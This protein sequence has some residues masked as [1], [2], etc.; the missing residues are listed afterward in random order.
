MTVVLAV[1]G[2]PQDFPGNTYPGAAFALNSGIWRLTVTPTAAS[3]TY[4]GGNFHAILGQAHGGLWFNDSSLELYTTPGDALVFSQLLTW[5]AATPI[6]IT[7]NTRPGAG[8]VTIA[9]ALTGNGTFSFTPQGP[10]V[11]STSTLGIGQFG[12]NFAFVGGVSVIDDTTPDMSWMPWVPPSPTRRAA[13]SAALVAALTFPVLVASAPPAPVMSWSPVIPA[14]QLR[15]AARPLN[16]GGASAPEATLPNASAPPSSWSPVFPDAPRRAR[17][18]VNEGGLVE[19]VATLPNASAPAMSWSPQFPGAPRAAR[20]VVNVGGMTHPE[21]VIPNAAAPGIGWA[22]EFPDLMPRVRYPLASG[23][24]APPFSGGRPLT[25]GAASIRQNILSQLAFS[26]PL[27]TFSTNLTFT[28]VAATDTLTTGTH[29]MIVT[30]GPF[31]LSTT[32]TLP[33][34]TDSTTFYYAIVASS[35]TIKLALTPALAKA[36]TAVDITD[37]GTGTHTLVRSVAT[38]PLYSTLLAIFARGTQSTAPDQATDSAG[39]TYSYIPSAPRPYDNFT[40]SSF[41]VSTSIGAHGGPAHSWSA[42]IGNIG[43]QQDE[44]VI[45]GIELFGAGILQSSSVV[46]R[47]DG[48]PT[49]ITSG[50]VTT[51]AKALLVAI[52]GGNGNVNQEHVFTTPAGFTRQA[53]I[54]A[55]GDPDPSGYIQVEVFTRIVDI[56]GTYTFSTQGTVSGAGP[57]GGMLWLLAFQTFV[58]DLQPL[59]WL[60]PQ[61]DPPRAPRRGLPG[62]ETAPPIQI[63]APAVPALSWAPRYPDQFQARARVQPPAVADPIVQPVPFSWLPQIPASARPPQGSR[64]AGETA[65]PNIT[66][67]FSWLPQIPDA[68]PGPR[69]S[70][71]HTEVSPVAVDVLLSWLP[72]AIEPSRARRS[73]PA[74]ETSPPVI[75]QPLPN[76]LPVYPDVLNRPARRIQGGAEGPVLVIPQA[77]V[78]LM[79]TWSPLASG[80]RLV[81]PLPAPPGAMVAPVLTIPNPPAPPQWWPIT[82]TSQLRAAARGQTAGQEAPFTAALVLAPPLVRLSPRV[83]ALARDLLTVT[84]EIDQPLTVTVEI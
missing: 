5:L 65:P 35:T 21:A 79:T 11:D 59:D 2:N 31:Q 83:S 24:T 60:Y 72:S 40:T 51:T 82:P 13:S 22:P 80:L 9:G 42:S 81:R 66:P 3:T 68:V 50:S 57:E 26:T 30:A 16:V 62:G 64:V 1:T 34:G 54:C 28:A 70:R 61:A 67:S 29:G 32:G 7:I 77:A 58:S 71:A 10:Y 43:G 69:R 19:P 25:V 36:G 27:S 76:W 52:V 18:A 73:Q 12:N 14:S 6:T 37:A 46:E 48:G 39:N 84:A 63:S 45:G 44:V 75:V 15:A 17:S 41:S 4:V 56:K 47:V 8:S 49:T 23:M 78:P 55:E 53:R 74:G 33:A 38:A 20:Q